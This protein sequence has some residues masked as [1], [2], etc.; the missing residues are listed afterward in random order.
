[1]G[2][3]PRR[4]RLQ[5]CPRWRAHMDTRRAFSVSVPAVRTESSDVYVRG[6]RF[7]A[8]TIKAAPYGEPEH[9]ADEMRVNS[10]AVVRRNAVSGAA[11]LRAATEA[12]LPGM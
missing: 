7:I 5:V 6:L 11:I 8:R 10:H 3:V 4:F 2:D 1:M 9:D 12:S